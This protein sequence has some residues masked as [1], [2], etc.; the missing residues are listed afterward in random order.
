[1]FSSHVLLSLATIVMFVQGASVNRAILQHCFLWFGN[2]GADAVITILLQTLKQ[3][4]CNGAM[5]WSTAF[6]CCESVLQKQ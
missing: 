2:T 4:S 6:F 3:F 1:M 5:D